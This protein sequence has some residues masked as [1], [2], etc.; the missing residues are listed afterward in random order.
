MSRD[1]L[2]VVLLRYRL[3][4]ARHDRQPG[5]LRQAPRRRFVAQQIEQVRAGADEG[6]SR[7]GASSGQ[8][9]ILRKKTVARVDGVDAALL[10]QRHD[11]IDV[12][13]GLDGSLA[14]ADEI[15]FVRLESMQAEAIFVGIDGGGADL[16]FVGG[17]E[18]ADGNFAAIQGQK[19][20]DR[21][22]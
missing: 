21:H 13:I 14:L 7:R 19:F 9:R 17:A 12:E 10:G 20:F 22:Q 4:R 1:A 16:Q 2:R 8:R 18:N 3:F 11:P 15:G 6:N 5:F